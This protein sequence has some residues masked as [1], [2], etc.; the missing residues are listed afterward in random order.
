M[1]IEKSSEKDPNFA[2]TRPLGYIVSRDVDWLDEDMEPRLR[3]GEPDKVRGEASTGGNPLLNAG[4]PEVPDLVGNWGVVAE[5]EDEEDLDGDPLN[6]LAKL[7]ED[8]DR[9]A[10]TLVL[11]SRKCSRSSGREVT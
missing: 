11:L 4:N 1:A 9:P 5:E 10:P 3:C 6:L 2:A 7:I 8:P